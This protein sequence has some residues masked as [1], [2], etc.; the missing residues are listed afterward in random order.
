MGN[1][2]TYVHSIVTS[3]RRL[4][5]QPSSKFLRLFLEGAASSEGVDPSQRTCF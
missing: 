4:L 1:V 3:V 2:D 5:K